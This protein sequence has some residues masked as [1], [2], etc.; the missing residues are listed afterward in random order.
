M[1]LRAGKAREAT[2]KEEKTRNKNRGRKRGMM[3][4]MRRSEAV[5]I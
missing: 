3:G 4:S 1:V 5:H 2:G